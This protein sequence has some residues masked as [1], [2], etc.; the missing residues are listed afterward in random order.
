MSVLIEGF[1][2]HTQCID[3]NKFETVESLKHKIYDKEG[4][5]PTQQRLRFGNKEMED[6][7]TLVHYHIEN[8]SV[9]HMSLRL[10]GGMPR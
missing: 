3:V 6:E 1:S 2:Y 8:G 4:V 9:I 10:R 7:K 5:T